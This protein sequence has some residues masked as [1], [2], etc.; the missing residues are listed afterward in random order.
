MIVYNCASKKFNHIQNYR[1]KFALLNDGNV[2]DFAKNCSNV[3]VLTE[4][5]KKER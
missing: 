5:I 3:R 1:P 2:P 4:K